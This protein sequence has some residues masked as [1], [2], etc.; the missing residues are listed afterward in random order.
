MH[1]YVFLKIVRAFPSNLLHYNATTSDFTPSNMQSVCLLA[2]M[3]HG[4]TIVSVRVEVVS[5]LI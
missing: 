4:V 3:T 1:R 5:G 2:V